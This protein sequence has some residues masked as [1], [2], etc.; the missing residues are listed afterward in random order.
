MFSLSAEL[1]TDLAL[2]YMLSFFKVFWV[3]HRLGMGANR[4][5]HK[6]TS[7]MTQPTA[8]RYLEKDIGGRMGRAVERQEQCRMKAG[9]EK[10]RWRRKNRGGG[11]G[12]EKKVW[13]G[14]V[15][16]K[17]YKYGF[18]PA[19]CLWQDAALSP[20]HSSLSDRESN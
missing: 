10:R 5:N 1:H 20:R 8:W 9:G 13:D 16:K 12:G 17:I 6:H 15:R 11:G 18:K 2:L 3:L 19:K 14:I 7:H 4:C